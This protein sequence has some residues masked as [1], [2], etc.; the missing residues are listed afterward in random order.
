[1]LYV[2]GP[3]EGPLMAMHDCVDRS[4]TEVRPG[5]YFCAGR[6]NVEHL[7]RSDCQARFF[8]GFAGW[9]AGQLEGELAEG[10]WRTRPALERHVFAADEEMW[11]RVLQ[12]IAGNEV[13]DALKIKH[14][15]PDPSMN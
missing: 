1:L 5:L 15:P 11:E 13:L 3:V 4:E 14:V 6:E 12:E 10:A 9:G 7:V 8:A 2:G